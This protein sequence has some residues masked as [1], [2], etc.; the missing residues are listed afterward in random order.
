MAPEE[1]RMPDMSQEIEISNPDNEELEKTLD[2]AF[3][4]MSPQER[5]QRM[6]VILSLLK[7]NPIL[8]EGVFQA[9]V[10][11]KRVGALFSQK[12]SDGTV[13]LWPPVML[14]DFSPERL[15]GSLER[16]CR[17]CKA[18]AA[19]ALVDRQQPFDNA[20]LLSLGFEYLSDML[21]LVVRTN[22]EEAAVDSKN[23]KHVGN[24]CAG[25]KV[26]KAARRVNGEF[27]TD[28]D[29]TL[30]FLPMS[31]VQDCRF[32][33]MAETVAKTYRN[34]RDFPRLLRLLPIHEVLNG[35][36]SEGPFCPD[37][38][39]F[40]RKED[41]DIGSLLMADQSEEQMELTYMGLAEE[42]RG[43]GY[44]REIVRFAKEIARHRKRRY[45]LTV[46]DEQNPAA[47]KSYLS[48]G[49]HTWDRKSVFVRFFNHITEC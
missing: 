30:E 22:E 18:S 7:D 47:L 41:R 33:R 28:F 24:R 15:F 49:F 11:G 35:Y 5:R 45:L 16:F 13:L 36:R 43:F 26:V 25:E 10:N 19:L 48:L 39:F 32:E 29:F 12:R 3:G 27:Q 31:R 6:D 38:W 1:K 46:V 8:R 42:A 17:R 4:Y 9:K 37:L 14:E 34:S 2:L 23:P 21:Y 44:G 20:G 40:V